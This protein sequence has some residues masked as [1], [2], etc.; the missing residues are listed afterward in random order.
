ML[1]LAE[2][3]FV[4]FMLL[5]ATGA[6]VPFLGG[7]GASTTQASKYEMAAQIPLYSTAAFFIILR[8]RSVWSSAWKTKWILALTMLAVVST[9]WS[10]TTLHVET[11]RDFGCHNVL[12]GL[13]RHSFCC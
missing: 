9:A 3:I 2:R 8:L 5:Y 11:K 10:S 13:F 1:R 6:I 12:R 7:H 4:F